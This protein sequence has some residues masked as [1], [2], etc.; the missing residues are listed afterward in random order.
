MTDDMALVREYAARN[1]EE[2]FATLVSRHVNL[3]YSV[4]LRQVRDPHLAEEITQAV[5]IILA[6][7]AGSLGPK[8]IL[9]GW[10]CRTARYA[11]ADALKSNAAA[12]AAN[13][14]PICNHVLNETG[15]QCLD[16]NRAAAGRRHGAARRKGPRR[17]GAPVF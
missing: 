8:T 11:A 9:S 10:L 7:K 16:A 2:A 4:A 12:N 15:I 13:R 14:R 17:P 5:F 6:R 1:S 3:V